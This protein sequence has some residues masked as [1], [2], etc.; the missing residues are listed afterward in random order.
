M[1]GETIVLHFPFAGGLDEKIAKE[2]LDASSRQA[3]I[4]NGDFVKVGAIDKRRGLEHLSTALISGGILPAL[5]TGTRVVGWSRSSLS[6]LCST[7]LYQ[8]VSAPVGGTSTGGVVGVAKLPYVLPSRKHITTGDQAAP[9]TLVDLTYHGQ[10]LRI[11]VFW[12]SSYNLL[13]SVY[14]VA[15]GNVVLEPTRIYT[16]SGTFG[17]GTIPRVVSGFDLPGIAD[18]SPRTVVVIQDGFDKSVKYVQYNPSTNAF[19]A[20]TTLAAAADIVDAVPYE[21]DPANGWLVYY[22]TSATN[23]RLAYWTAAGLQTTQDQTLLSLSIVNPCYVAA[24]YGQSVFTLCST[25]TGGN[26][27]HLALERNADHTFATGMGSAF[28]FETL[29]GSGWW[30]TGCCHLGTN[31][32][33]VS[34]YYKLANT[35]PGPT[36]YL[37]KWQVLQ[38]SAGNITTLA[39]GRTPFGFLAATRPFVVSGEVYQPYYYNLDYQI[40]GTLSR[41]QQI[42]LYLAKFEGVSDSMSSTTYVVDNCRPVATI[43]PRTTAHA[44]QAILD[45]FGLF[46]TG[47]P[48]TVV[49]TATQVAVGLKT[50]G[51]T[52]TVAGPSWAVDFF[53]DSTSAR[54]LYQTSELGSELSISGGVPFVADG[55]SAFEDGFFNY[56]ELS[57]VKL[58]G[59]GTPLATGQYTFAV[60]YR[61][62]DSSGLAHRSAPYI[63]NPVSVTS[64]STAP[65]IYITPPIASYRDA[66]DTSTTVG[67]IYADIYM[68][69]TDGGTL[70]YKDSIV[71]SN[72]STWPTAI[73]YP[74]S[75]QVGST[76]DTTGPIL[77]T[78]G[79]VMDNVNPPASRI[80]IVHQNRKAIA[81]ETLQQVWFSKAFSSGDA[82][83]FNEALVVP[84]PDGGPL[85]A[86][87]SM[88]GKFIA[89][90]Q[91]S[92]WM[93]EGDGPTLTGLGSSWTEPQSISTDV[94]M[95][96]WQSVVLMP[97][98]VMFQA[99][100]NGIYLLGR[101][102]QVQFIGKSVI[103]RTSA[104]PNI[105]SASLVPSLTQ[106]RFV[107]FDTANVNHIVVV[108]DY[109]LDAWTTHQYGQL[110]AAPVS[111]CVSYD[112][113]PRYTVL[114]LDGNVWQERLST[115]AARYQDQDSSGVNHFVTTTIKLPSIKTQTQGFQRARAVQFFGEQQDDCGLQIDLAFNYDD[116]VRQS[117][118][119]S[120]TQ[121]KPLNIRG[122]VEARVAAAYNKQMAVQ[123]TVS[124]TAGAAMTTGAGMRFAALALELQNLGPKYKLLPA[125]ARR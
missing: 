51:D 117:E 86:L 122:Q 11:A 74:T 89:G 67:R 14:D 119:W 125:G 91:R 97:R 79:G 10:L 27:F 1:A 26:T 56:P 70:Y 8:Y 44:A 22:N 108:Y 118:S 42:T 54:D 45:F 82:P 68:T 60:V 43:A 40:G 101:D 71:V 99:P 12:D 23:M 47:L 84:F 93:M 109:L 63:C 88:D 19:T 25:F 48:S 61:S 7:G 35:S 73:R 33:F 76:P 3:S 49:R 39:S 13:A 59:G 65:A 113:T 98:G 24:R 2:Y 78:T 124:D 41:S 112:S 46:H 66:L 17:A 87:A 16:N 85:T 58:E 111:T 106:V 80:Q 9:P 120:S 116:T 38:Y 81:D 104:Y 31:K 18:G 102:L 15:S 37:S 57:Y 36:S 114:T 50:T 100:N 55:Q 105:V 107:C 30:L 94:G 20:T 21:D 115:D 5:A 75:G 72:I 95:K 28:G 77:Y 83:G 103:D 64:G 53:W 52:A 96:S 92:I 29:A 34:Y 123:I 121:L 69:V 32:I 62:V 4:V 6:I 90:K 110:S